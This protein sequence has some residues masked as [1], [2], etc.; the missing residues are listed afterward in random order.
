MVVVVLVGILTTLA[1]I[2]L[3]GN[4]ALNRLEKEMS[5]IGALLKLASDEAVM[6]SRDIGLRVTLDSYEFFIYEPDVASW[7]RVDFDPMFRR[8]SLPQGLDIDLRLDDLDA[9][10]P[11][12]EDEDQPAPQVVFFSS[13]DVTPFALVLDSE[14]AK[15]QIT[16]RTDALGRAELEH[17]YYG[18]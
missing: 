15:T 17:D 8:R 14:D 11:E 3:G 5:R 9:F 16:L 2:N 1:V 10:I 6:Q 4:P 13:G 7:T 12:S 18:F